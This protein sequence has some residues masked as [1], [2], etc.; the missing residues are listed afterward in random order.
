MIPNQANLLPLHHQPLVIDDDDV[1]IRHLVGLST[2]CREPSSKKTLLQ[3]F[4]AYKYLMM[5]PYRVGTRRL[6]ARVVF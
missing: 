1:I 4:G 5:H 6:G 2:L 3:D